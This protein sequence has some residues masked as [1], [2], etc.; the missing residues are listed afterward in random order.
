MIN[1]AAADSGGTQAPADGDTAVID[2]KHNHARNPSLCDSPRAIG[3]L[4]RVIRNITFY[5]SIME[6]QLKPAQAS[7]GRSLDKVTN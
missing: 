4:T 7:F 5:A 3:C 2:A 1:R 6:S